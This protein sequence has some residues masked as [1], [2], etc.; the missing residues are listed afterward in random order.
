M[1]LPRVTPKAPKDTIFNNYYYIINQKKTFLND[2]E[3]I[4]LDF[5]ANKKTIVNLGN[6][7]VNLSK[8]T[9]HVIHQNS[10][11][12]ETFGLQ[13]LEPWQVAEPNYSN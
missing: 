3:C 7:I 6:K 8:K 9:I 4:V 1:E 10:I 11:M 5:C 13:V 12:E 2:L